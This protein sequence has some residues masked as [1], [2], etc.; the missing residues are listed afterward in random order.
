MSSLQSKDSSTVYT[1]YDFQF[2]KIPSPSSHLE[3]LLNHNVVSFV[4]YT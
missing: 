4:F 1:G 2:V 3:I